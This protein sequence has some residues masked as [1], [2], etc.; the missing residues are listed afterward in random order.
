MGGFQG[1]T[2]I[3][4]A[5]N[6]TTSLKKTVEEIFRVCDSADLHELILATA[7]FATPACRAVCDEI[8]KNN[9][10][11]VPVRVYVQTG[12]F[13]DAIRDLT[14]LLSGSHFIYQPT[15]LEED[16]SLLAEVIRLAKQHPDAVISGSRRRS[17]QGF[18]GFS[19]ARRALYGAWR[20][21]F[22]ALYGGGVTDSTLLYRCM[23]SAPAKRIVLNA[24]SYA[25]LFE[26]FVKLLRMGVPVIEF[27]VEMGRRAEGASSTRFFSDGLRYARVLFAVRFTP[28]NKFLR[29]SADEAEKE[30]DL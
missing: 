18:S 20:L 25:V 14:A 22:S 1:L 29:P 19:P 2:V 6:E 26:L 13:E 28:V 5:V 30:A 27:P 8:Q 21:L 10:A 16:P 3:L 15:D 17:L 12:P 23:P 24:G 4:P 7:D 11:P 9:S